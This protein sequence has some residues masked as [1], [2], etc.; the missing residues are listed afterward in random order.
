ML[1]QRERTAQKII[2]DLFNDLEKSKDSSFKDIQDV[3]MKVYQKL[4]DPKI[5]QAPLVNRLVNY[6]SFTA[7]TK[8][9][10]FSS[11]Q[12]EWIMELSTIGR[13]AGLNGVYRSDYGDKNQF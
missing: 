6:I 12:N 3:L 9:L 5:E 4:D 8:K 1:N 13:K 10:K 7:I 2:H 11:M